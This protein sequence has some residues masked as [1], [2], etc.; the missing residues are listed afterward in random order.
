MN[1]PVNVNFIY[2][3]VFGHPLRSVLAF[4]SKLRDPIHSTP[5]NRGNP[6]TDT[7]IIYISVHGYTHICTSTHI[8]TDDDI[9]Y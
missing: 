5:K 9:G 1:E 6:I 3:D 8:S 7:R 2:P 4:E